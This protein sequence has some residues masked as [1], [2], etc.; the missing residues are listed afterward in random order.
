MQAEAVP[1]C[2]SVGSPEG[3]RDRGMVYVCTGV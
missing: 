3:G 2:T 1:R